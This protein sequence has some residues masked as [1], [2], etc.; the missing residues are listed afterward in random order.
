[1]QDNKTKES[2]REMLQKVING[3]LQQ[4]KQF[5]CHLMTLSL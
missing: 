1:M 5:V 2:L 4:K 3:I